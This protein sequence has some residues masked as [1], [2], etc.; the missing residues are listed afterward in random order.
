MHYHYSDEYSAD[1]PLPPNPEFSMLD[2]LTV[3]VVWEEP[4]TWHS[5]PITNY[6]VDVINETS[7]ELIDSTVLSPDM[8]SYTIAQRG[9]LDSCTPL[10]FKVNATNDVGTSFSGCVNGSLPTSKEVQT[11]ACWGREWGG[12]S[13]RAS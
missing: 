6:S 8:L 2:E 13:G 12:V 9:P 4:F 11:A 10:L 7:A 3:Q 1:V 5:F